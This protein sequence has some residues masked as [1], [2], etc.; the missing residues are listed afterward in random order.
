[1]QYVKLL[2]GASAS[3]EID[4]D[5]TFSDAVSEAWFCVR[6]STAAE[7]ISIRPWM[8]GEMNAALPA[9]DP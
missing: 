9:I 5:P 1:M 7:Q 6:P 8:L 3:L 2:P 4:T